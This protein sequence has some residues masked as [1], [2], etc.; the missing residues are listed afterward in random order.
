MPEGTLR[1][2]ADTPNGQ[3]HY[4]HAGEGPPLLI[5]HQTASCSEQFEGMIPMLASAH[6]VLALDTPGYGMSDPPPQQY[7]IPDYARSVVEF[8]DTLGVERTSIF[9]RHTGAAIATEVAAVYPHRVD[10]LVL[11]GV[12]YYGLPLEELEARNRAFPMREDGGHLA[13]IWDDIIGRMREGL[14][15]KPYDPE[16]LEVIEREVIWKLMV[17]ERCNAGYYAIYRYDILERLPLIQAPTL[18]LTGD[19]DV[20]RSTLEIVAPKIKRVR[21]RVLEGGSYFTSYDNPEILAREILDFLA[22]PGV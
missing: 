21:T 4:R 10:G 14:Y 22:Q 2:Y 19:Q 13:E 18:V 12:P 11:Y 3:L 20:M 6:R 5:L 16:A 17:R 1:A 8:L 9:A 15:P 7:M